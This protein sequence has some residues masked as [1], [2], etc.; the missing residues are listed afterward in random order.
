MKG[1]S[2]P[3]PLKKRKNGKEKLALRVGGGGKR[4]RDEVAVRD[5]EGR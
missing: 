2:Q 5:E 1:E 3:G 4:E